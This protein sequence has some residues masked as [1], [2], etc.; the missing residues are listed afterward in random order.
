MKQIKTSLTI[1]TLVFI[2]IVSVFAIGRFVAPP[3]SVTLA[4]DASSEATGTNATNYIYT[5]YY[6]PASGSFTNK[7]ETG[8]TNTSLTITNLGFGSRYFFV[9]TAKRIV[10]Q[11]ES[12]Y[13]NEIFYDTPKLPMKPT[14]LKITGL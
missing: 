14:T 7:Q 1:F 2:S 3:P 11:L 13:S 8:A 12:D 5:V 4:W 10:D 6:G 9:A